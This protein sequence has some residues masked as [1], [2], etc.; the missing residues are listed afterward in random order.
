MNLGIIITARCNA[1]CEHCSKSY[2]PN[3][4]EKLG[5]AEI[6]RLMD[7]AA[8]I[9]DG[10]PLK[11]DITGGEPFLDFGLLVEIVSHGARLGGVVTCVTNAFWARTNE[12]ARSKLVLLR[13]SGLKSLSVSVSRFHQRYVPLHRARRALENAMDLGIST[14]LKGA[15]TMR[16]LAPGGALSE[17]ESCL[18]A[19]G[20]NIFPV[21]PH[22]RQAA[23]L[24]DDEYYREAGLPE[25]K[26]PA[27]EVCIDFNGIARSCCGPGVST[28]DFLVIGNANRTSV[29]EI[30]QYLR[31][32]GKHRILRE[33][34][35]IGFA[36]AAIAAGIGDSL[37]ASYAGPCD[38]CMHIR[39]DP[40]LR[41][42]AEDM[43]HAAEE[44][45]SMASI[46]AGSI[47]V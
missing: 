28:G 12:L 42:V 29:D 14:E 26:C 37:R 16:D 20:I 18:N 45:D 39:T 10:L 9:D 11:Y 36:R 8:A 38:L 22:L 21:L 23:T 31:R 27:E 34:G 1:S 33:V 15:I 35:P 40:H 13:D 47:P 24:P 3:R 2:G 17:W 7:E 5:R 43:G 46:L 32:S 25:H 44:G 19:D 30:N 41:Q 4:T 6:F